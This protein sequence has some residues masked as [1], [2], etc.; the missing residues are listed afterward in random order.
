M[1][2]LLN[3]IFAFLILLVSCSKE[4]QAPAPPPTPTFTLNF[5]AD[6]GGTVSTEGGT[7]N[8]GSKITVT[9]TPDGQFLFKEWSDGSTQNPREITVT[10]NLTLKA[11]FIKKTYPLAVTVEGEGTVQEE[12]IIQGST[13]ETTYNAGT[14]VRLTATPNEGWVFAGWSG[15]VESEE[16][17]IEIPIE[18]GTVLTA[19]F[20]PI[21]IESF[22]STVK[23]VHPWTYEFLLGK[24]YNESDIYKVGPAGWLSVTNQESHEAYYY[25]TSSD[26]NPAGYF[27]Q[28]PHNF[29]LGDYNG[30]GLQDVLITWAT[31]PH[32]ILR[33]SKFTYTFLINNGDGSLSFDENVITSPSIQNRHFAY[34]TIAADFNGDNIDDIVSASMGLIK[35]LPDGEF[36]TKWESIPLM[37]S[38]GVGSYYDAS[39]N[40]EGQE[41]GVSPPQGHSFG[42]EISVGDVDGDGDNDIYT[43][44]TLLLNDGSGYFTNETDKLPNE[45]R[46]R[47]NL[48]SSVIA[49]FN[50]DGVDDF[51]VPYAEITG[52]SYLDDYEDY[53]GAYYIS[54]NGG[55]DLEGRRVGFVTEAK[56]GISN[57]KFN[58]AI[59]YDVNLD[60]FKDIVIA[61]TRAEPYYVGK[62]LQIFLNEY[63]EETQSRKF[64]SGDHLIP[65]ESVLD[66]THGEGQLTSI[67]I[68]ND[69][70]L[71]IA[72][73][74]GAYGEDYGISL[75]LNV[76]GSLQLVSNDKLVYVTDNQIKERGNFGPY[77][78]LRRTIPI[79]LNNSGW[80]DMISTVGF[81][82]SDGS[83]ELIFYS[84]L[85]KE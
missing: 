69:G 82:K 36:F 71:D 18:K 11:S 45:L 84:I 46:P 73:T 48:W 27:T 38:D 63:D 23:L 42:H 75:Y 44:K 57:T 6:T 15:D 1:K 35:R 39:T 19:V 74:S 9:A 29:A 3:S 32:T 26:Y 62:G 52:N 70:V 81:G 72:H 8:Q 60:G 10:S 66:Q 53:S 5:S 49:D 25:P 50:N 4:E 55:S 41:D 13:T 33:E 51:F 56:Y 59:A 34:R 83:S 20:R 16:L 40:I 67:D 31:F 68:N 30:D 58:Y 77:G 7:Y 64:V 22:I 14:T 54:V 37:L 76:G 12:V 17:V 78:K 65:D 21:Q 47:R 79:N 85:S 61:T 43:G 24:P 2:K 80:I 28:D